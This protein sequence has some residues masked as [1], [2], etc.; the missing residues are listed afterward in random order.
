MTDSGSCSIPGGQYPSDCEITEGL[1]QRAMSRQGQE[2]RG[3]AWRACLPK[4]KEIQLLLLD[5]DGVLTDGT[6][7]YG[8]GETEL[9]GFNIKDGFGITL[10]REAGVEVGII[11]ARRSEAVARRAQDLKLAHVYQGVRNKIEAFSEILAAQNLTPQQ[12]AYMGDDW[13]DLPLLSRVGLA[14]TVADA[15]VEVREIAHYVT[16]QAGGRGAVREVCELIIEA[17][18]MRAELFARYLR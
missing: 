17:K 2:E 3:Y 16:R 12:I 11:T 15:A 1:R 5:V 7:V 18:G 8:N 14:A 4:A 6:I 13:L 9:K 10:L